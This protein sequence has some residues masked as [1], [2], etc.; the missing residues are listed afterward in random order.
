MVIDLLKVE[1]FQF[2]ILSNHETD[3]FPWF[4]PCFIHVSPE[5][6]PHETPASGVA[7]ALPAALVYLALLGE[8]LGGGGLCGSYFQPSKTI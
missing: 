5:K 3:D 4:P 6:V 7:L 8:I 1:I 2:A